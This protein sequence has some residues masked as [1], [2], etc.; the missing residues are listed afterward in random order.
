MRLVI[1]GLALAWVLVAAVLAAVVECTCQKSSTTVNGQ[2]LSVKRDENEGLR[3]AAEFFGT[4]AL[5]VAVIFVGF[6]I[7]LKFEQ[8]T[9]AVANE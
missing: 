6:A 9:V 2:S 5:P 7:M 4:S 1:L 3:G 8:A